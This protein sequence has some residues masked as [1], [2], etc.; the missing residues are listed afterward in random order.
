LL[1]LMQT[2]RYV[3]DVGLDPAYWLPLLKA[4][5][6]IICLQALPYVGRKDYEKLLPDCKAEWEKE[7]L[8]NIFNMKDDNSEVDNLQKERLEKAKKRQQDCRRMLTELREMYEQGK[9][10]SDHDVKDK[11]QKLQ[12]ELEIPPEY[13]T[14][15]TAP[16]KAVIEN[17]QKQLDCMEVS[18]QKS[19]NLSDG[20]I[21]KNASGGL[22]LEGIYKTGKLEDLMN[23]REQLIDLPQSFSLT[24]PRETQVFEQVEVSSYTMEAAFRK[25]MEKMGRSIASTVKGGGWGFSLDVQQQQNTS[26][27]S[28][29]ASNALTEK[30][31][32]CT[33]KYNYIP[34]ASCFMNKLDLSLTKAALDE[35]KRI[36]MLL[37]NTGD[38]ELQVKEIQTFFDRFGSHANQGPLHFGGI[39]WWKASCE[40]FHSQEAE[41]VRKITSESLSSY[42][43]AS[44]S[45]FSLNVS[46][47]SGTEMSSFK[48]SDGGKKMDTLRSKIHLT[49]SKTG[50]P[51]ATDQLLQWKTGLTSSSK[52]WSVI[53]R[54]QNLVPVWEIILCSHSTE[55]RNVQT[56]ADCLA[57]GY[58]TLS[59]LKTSN[60]SGTQL[61]FIFKEAQAAISNIKSWNASDPEKHLI[62]LSEIKSKLNDKTKNCEAWINICL[63]DASLQN[64]FF[65]I[66]SIHQASPNE[67]ST[68]LKSVICGLLLPEINKTYSFLKRDFIM[69]WLKE[70]RQEPE[71]EEPVHNLSQLLKI[72]QDAKSDMQS[73]LTKEDS[74]EVKIKITIKIT[75]SISNINKYFIEMR[76]M[77]ELSL[78]VTIVMAVGYSCTNNSFQGLLGHP[79]IDFIHNEL[80]RAV[81]KYSSLRSQ[82]PSKS[83]AFLI[84]NGLTVTYEC[85]VVTPEMK[86]QRLTFLKSKLK[87]VLSQDIAD[88]LQHFSEAPSEWDKLVN[89]MDSIID[90]TYQTNNEGIT[91]MDNLGKALEEIIKRNSL[92]KSEK[93]DP[94]T[95]EMYPLTDSPYFSVIERLGLKRFYPKQLTM[96]DI[97]VI[98]K[99][100]LHNSQPSTEQELPFCLLQ[101]LLIV[102]YRA[103]E[104]TTETTEKNSKSSLSNLQIK[105]VM[106]VEDLLD[107]DCS[108]QDDDIATEDPASLHFMDV[109]MAVYH[110]ADMSLWQYITSKLSFC[111]FA[112]PLLIPNPFDDHIE[113]PLWSFQ[114]L[115]KSWKCSIKSESGFKGRNKNVCKT[116]AP[117]VSFIRLGPCSSSKSQLLNGLLNKGKH[118]TF[119]HRDCKGAR[120]KRLFMDGVVEISW[121][122]PAGKEDD[123]F[124]ECIAFMNLRGDSREHDKQCEFLFEVSSVNV[125]VF[126]D[127]HAKDSKGKEILQ[128][129]LKSPIPFI[130][131]L[132]DK[133]KVSKRSHES[134]VKIP[135]LNRNQADLLQ[136]LRASIQHLLAKAQRS[137]NIQQC[138][139][140]ARKL[141]VKV[142]EDDEH[143]K[144]AKA[145]AESLV[146]PLIGQPLCSVKE[147]FFP[148][149]GDLWHNWCKKNKE[150]TR[151]QVKENRSLEQQ[152]SDFENEKKKL[153][154]EQC[155]RADPLNMVMKCFIENLNLKSLKSKRVFLNWLGIEF[156]ELTCDDRLK[157]EQELISKW[158]QMEEL[159]G[160]GKK[161]DSLKQEFEE[162]STMLMASSLGLEHV[163]RELGQM[164]EALL[165]Q[166]GN[167]GIFI[168]LSE[169]AA[170][171]MISGYPIELMDG[172]A[173]H[174]PV[175]WVNAVLEQVIEKLG[176]K[177]IFVLS[178]LGIQSTGKSTLLNAM[179]GLQFATSA[180]RCTRGAFMQLIKIKEDLL[181]LDF[182]YLL[183]VDTEGLRALEFADKGTLK[184]DNELATFVIGIANL[185]LINIFG[186]NPSD[187]QDILEI[188]GQAFLRMKKVKLSPS[189]CFVHQNV[190]EI[191]AGE[192]NMEGRR[193]LEERLDFMTQTAAKQ[194]VC[195]VTHFKDV[196]RF[197]INRHVFYFSHLWEGNPPMA[198]PNPNYSEN[199]QKLK[200]M[201]LSEDM[202]EGILK[203]SEFK[204][205]VEDLWSA[206]LDEDFVFSFKNT[207][208]VAAYRRLEEEYGKWNWE[209]RRHMLETENQLRNSIEN[210]KLKK[211]EEFNLKGD[212]HEK[213][214]T[215]AQK[216]EEYFAKDK[217]KDLMVQWKERTQQNFKDLKTDLVKA[218][219]RK[220]NEFMK[221]KDGVR[222]LEEQ[223]GKYEEE[224]MK[225]SRDLALE[226]KGKHLQ[227]QELE[228]KFE[229]MW[230]E[231]V[232]RL[233][234][235]MPPPIEPNIEMNVEKVLN[236]KYD[237][238]IIHSSK[239]TESYKKL[240]EIKLN[241][242]SV[243]INMKVQY[244]VI[245][246]IKSVFPFK[247]NDQDQQCMI[248]LTS[249]IKQDIYGYIKE[250]EE[251]R[252]D[253]NE[254]YIYEIV[255]KIKDHVKLFDCNGGR[256]DIKN[257]YPADMALLLFEEAVVPRF[258]EMHCIFQK[259]NYPLEYLNS[260]KGEYLKRFKMFSTGATAIAVLAYTVAEKLKLAIRQEV[261]DRSLITITDLIKCNDPAL[262]GNRSNMENHILMALVK[263]RNF[264]KFLLYIWS[265]EEHFAEFIKTQ[266]K[267][268]FAQTNEDIFLIFRDQINQIKVTVCTAFLKSV[269]NS[270]TENI[271]ISAWLER[272]CS[273]LG[274][275]IVFSKSNMRG[276]D[277]DTI[278]D[279][280]FFKE[281]MTIL[282]ETV[283]AD[284]ISEFKDLDSIDCT[285]F[286]RQ[287]HD[288]LT[289]QLSGCWV[290]CPFCLASCESTIPNHGGQHSVHF[291]RPRALMGGKWH[292]TDRFVTEIC[293]TLEDK[294]IPYRQYHSGGPGYGSWSITPERE[295]QPIWK[296]FVCQFKSDL[297]EH[298]KLRFTDIPEQWNEIKDE[299]VINHLIKERQ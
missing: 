118:S 54:G 48:G 190:G 223:K 269:Q 226:L 185:T 167:K 106:D 20:E 166:Q 260:K 250:K 278:Q 89:Q 218:A 90:G 121:Y 31:Y 212:V 143:C 120:E 231:W 234:A 163:L 24:G 249:R 133:E 194:E 26:S 299:E 81:E 262:N 43:G 105:R 94:S 137:L 40:G 4:K 164:Y 131:L 135:L 99:F 140:V 156:D 169:L 225:M 209:L 25:L 109:Q 229:K 177:R 104:I 11:K 47:S 55:F 30:S 211:K 126:K 266:V 184:H 41:Q 71:K 170:D 245:N 97:L 151:L 3:I 113:F 292:K 147:K 75:N 127:C 9:E 193:R 298:Y 18:L 186:E 38:K 270:E 239:D 201:L 98:D 45:G 62:Q 146:K 44:Y 254:S 122:C 42:I 27:D 88:I 252:V 110:C 6:G 10:Q 242:V 258:K 285:A 74:Q 264:D 82:S 22:T 195:D 56:V 171:L 2:Y 63:S 236:E 202:K 33:T 189:C 103:R 78:L 261:Y 87:D 92:I 112:L 192:A 116:P 228:N 149:Q 49:V 290:Q 217:D 17:M 39:Y 144:E 83:Q 77:E 277:S 102:D 61:D 16:L 182:D 191:T 251:I 119:Y 37:I 50:G 165:T 148:L 273:A 93:N 12:T 69:N 274:N 157:M 296:W 124:N 5:L 51:E 152:R 199:V 281:R 134:I 235:G 14:T 220:L 243:Y 287:P 247:S 129:L 32:I 173:S 117:V 168:S 1:T 80:E 210:N 68:Y 107:E 145:A 279:V 183:V 174:V 67:N 221:M 125:V 95:S 293:S 267:E 96:S 29:R 271:Q 159:K 123:Q 65:D 153:R 7:A 100:S 187:M 34:L 207:L 276:Y 179:F 241:D 288:I 161:M 72:L 291:H 283:A 203:I 158:S 238:K 64:F 196:I 57:K 142:D 138:A 222:N 160:K 256:F 150:L 176:D 172:D 23:Q 181:D 28:T 213:Y 240:K 263:E 259:A 141:G 154:K 248:D 272:F 224:L 233:T 214:E 128:K 180:G 58:E 85:A 155:R 268:Y 280:R 178:V 115:K 246:A 60:L 101:K 286:R 227:D 59:G 208:E 73:N 289:E 206:L 19:E 257:E 204:T 284:L 52:T 111:Q 86:T 253:Y 132:D 70:S 297:E 205:R 84:T 76:Q 216:M 53:D 108:I 139:D 175:T 114:L 8:K 13:W 79:E 21:V 219:E 282:L 15:S 188:V 91:S 200:Q 66:A 244:K 46:A 275:T 162:K 255:N 294:W 232:T 230:T 237:M 215:L 36:E 136:E 198:P 265:P 197:D 295:F 130:C 35:L